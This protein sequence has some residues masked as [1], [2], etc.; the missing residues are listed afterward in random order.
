MPNANVY[1][2]Q[3]GNTALMFAAQNGHDGCLRLLMAGK[4]DGK[5]AKN[6]VRG[7]TSCIICITY[8]QAL[9]VFIFMII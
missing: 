4:D 5:I 2:S 8:M 1:Q 9:L 6:K 3:D 7:G